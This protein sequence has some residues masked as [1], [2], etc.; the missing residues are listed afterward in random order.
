VLAGVGRAGDEFKVDIGRRRVVAVDRDDAVELD[1]LRGEIGAD[2]GE[3]FAESR[4]VRPRR[5]WG[6]GPR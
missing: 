5:G 4:R 6:C 1:D 3:E 2:E